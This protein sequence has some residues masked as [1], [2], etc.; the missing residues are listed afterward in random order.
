MV[1][2]DVKV[3]PDLSTRNMADLMGGIAVKGYTH[4]ELLRLR[5]D[6]EE[7]RLTCDARCA[8]LAVMSMSRRSSVPAYLI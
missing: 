1:C 4:H 6:S 3:E 7:G 8:C 2:D 5:K